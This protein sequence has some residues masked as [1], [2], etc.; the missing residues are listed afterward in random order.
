MGAYLIMNIDVVRK[1]RSR[2]P[3][4]AGSYPSIFFVKLSSCFVRVQLEI[5]IQSIREH[6]DLRTNK[7]EYRQQAQAVCF[8]SK[9]NVFYLNLPVV[10]KGEL[11]SKF[12]P[13]TRNFS[14]ETYD[15]RGFLLLLMLLS[16][17]F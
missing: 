15:C 3:S 11:P 10:M 13:S 12:I 5:D 14:I 2:D 16:N 1:N 6:E 17:V 4:S 8:Y 7:C 9:Y